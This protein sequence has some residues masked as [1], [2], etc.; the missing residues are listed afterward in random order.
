MMPQQEVDADQ[1]V[2]DV[3]NAWGVIRTGAEP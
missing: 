3:L 2:Q 1:A